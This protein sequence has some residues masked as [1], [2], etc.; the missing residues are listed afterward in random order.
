[1]GRAIPTPPSGL[2]PGLDPVARPPLHRRAPL[3]ARGSGFIPTPT[4]AGTHAVGSKGNV[5]TS[6]ALDGPVAPSAPLS[7][8]CRHIVDRHPPFVTTPLASLHRVNSYGIY[9][10]PTLLSLALTAFPSVPVHGS[11]NKPAGLC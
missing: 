9:N 6:F 1:M 8:F 2:V 10:P 4:P 11:N 5:I 3:S 7:Q